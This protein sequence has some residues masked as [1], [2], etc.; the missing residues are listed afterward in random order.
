M[1]N[2]AFIQIDSNLFEMPIVFYGH[3]S[4]SE[5]LEAVRNVLSRTD[6]IG[7]P[8]YLSAQIFHEFSVGLRD[9]DG[10]LGFGISVGVVGSGEW[11]DTD[12]IYVNA[13]TGEYRL[14]DKVYSEFTITTNRFGVIEKLLH[15]NG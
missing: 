10:G 4:G 1:G 15:Q 14:G 11:A 8:S 6:R 9:Y 2:R 13:D 3:W 5:N 7:D 12:T